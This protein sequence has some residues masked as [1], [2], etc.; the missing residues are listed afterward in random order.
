M[1][2]T[3]EFLMVIGCVLLHS[4]YPVT[5]WD[6]QDGCRCPG[7]Q[8]CT[9][10]SW[11]PQADST[12]SRMPHISMHMFSTKPLP[13]SIINH[14]YESQFKYFLWKKMHLKMMFVKCWPICS[15]LN[16]LTFLGL[17]IHIY[18]RERCHICS[19]QIVQY[20]DIIGNSSIWGHD[21]QN[22]G[23]S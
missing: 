8:I 13:A 15:C 23:T 3:L 22:Y 14:H 2:K 5:G 12:T 20:G 6:C 1:V 7:E 19:I 11:R 10:P 4:W 9:R 21:Q 16:G 17:I 18:I